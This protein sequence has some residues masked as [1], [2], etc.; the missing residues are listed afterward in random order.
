MLRLILILLWCSFSLCSSSK[1]DLVPDR[2]KYNPYGVV[3]DRSSG[4]P[5]PNYVFM[6]DRFW[7]PQEPRPDRFVKRTRRHR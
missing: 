6:I 3:I 7:S 2:Y 4:R 5:V 1:K